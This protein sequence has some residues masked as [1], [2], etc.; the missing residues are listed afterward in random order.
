MNKLSFILFFFF[1][2]NL[3]AAERWGVFEIELKGPKTENP[4]IDIWVSAEFKYKNQ[5][6]YVDGFYDG[7]QTYKI[8]FM[9][10][11]EGEWTY[12]IKSNSNK[13]KAKHGSFI[14]TPPTPDNHGRVKIRDTYHFGYDDGTPFYPVGTTAY[15]W[16]HQEN[17]LIKETLNTLKKNTFNKI[18]MTVMP[19]Y[20]GKYVSNE[21]PF[22]PFEGSE[23]KGWKRDR[24]N[25]DFFKHLEN[26][27][28]ALLELNIQADIILFHP[29][30]KW[31]FSKGS[32]EENQL[33]LKY[34][35]ARLGAYRNVWWS[36][37]NE[38]DI[39][40]KPDSEWEIYFKT[41]LN[42]DPSNHLKSIHNG[43]GWYNHSKPW[44]THLSVQTP[45]L[46]KT[47]EWRETY[48][49]PVIN[50]EFVYE[51]NIPFD[52]GNLTAEETVLRFWTL[53]TRGGYGSHGETYVHPENI[54][55]WAKGGKLYGKSPERIAFF[56]QIMK[57]A[58]EVDLVPL[59]TEWNKAMELYKKDDYYLY[60]YGNSQQ[61]S[62]I[63]KLPE[64]KKYIIEVI[65]TWNMT[66]SKL[67]KLYSGTIEIEL[68]QKPYMAIRARVN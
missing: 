4:F 28:I 56:H 32:I 12:T 15:S 53:Y 25:V 11:F 1:T 9:P 34:L 57:E 52:W 58:P 41:I 60:Y 14:C 19:K 21:P 3:C 64:D 17:D 46:E 43:K 29:Y 31:G 35:I 67:D 40:N 37:A 48:N 22:Y 61:A 49:K 8:R 2:I 62:A 38:Y 50:D 39:M 23:E 6:Y 13:I 51:G 18:R 59:H 55:W 24:F 63:I 16:I 30:D 36:M 42:A 20:Y 27:V 68:P 66:I 33:Y 54:L 44:I 45:F 65:D 26:Q 5:I 47:Q 7:N 10:E